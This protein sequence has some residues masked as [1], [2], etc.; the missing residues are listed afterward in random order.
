[1]KRVIILF[2]ILSISLALNSCKAERAVNSEGYSRNTYSI[3]VK[4]DSRNRTMT[5]SEILNYINKN[6]ME[7]LY[8]HLYPNVYKEKETAPEFSSIPKS[9]P[10]GFNEGYIN[11][12]SVKIN[13]SKVTYAVEGSL[14]R[15][16]IPKNMKQKDS[17]KV[18]IAFN[19]LLPDAKTRYGKYEGLTHSS[20]WYPILAVY[21]ENGWD[22]AAFHPIGESSYSE[23]ADY[24]VKITLPQNEIIAA[25]GEKIGERTAS[26]GYKTITYK[27][28]NIRDF[29]WFSSAGF[30]V[31]EKESNGVTYRYYYVDEGN[32]D[33]KEVLEQSI[34][35]FDFYNNKFGAYPYKQFNI[36]N[37]KLSTSEFPE[38][39]TITDA[40]LG[41]SNKLRLAFAH[42]IAHQWWYLT[43]GNN[44]YKEPWLDEALASYSMHLYNE[45]LYGD[46]STK[47]DIIERYPEKSH[48]IPINSPVNKFEAMSDYGDVVY[49]WGSIALNELSNK[50]GKTD[51]YK[52]LNG[53]YNEY[54]FKNAE[55]ADFLGEI[56][57]AADKETAEWFNNILNI[58]KHEAVPKKQREALQAQIM[59][60]EEAKLESGQMLAFQRMRYGEKIL[61]QAI[62]AHS[63]TEIQKYE[64][65]MP[66]LKLQAVDGLELDFINIVPDYE[67]LKRW[68]KDGYGK[69]NY[70]IQDTKDIGACVYSYGSYGSGEDIRIFILP[71]TSVIE[72]NK[73]Y[74]FLIANG[75]KLTENPSIY[76]YSNDKS[77]SAAYELEYK[78]NKFRIIILTHNKEKIKSIA[79]DVHKGLVKK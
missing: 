49:K 74:D 73:Q 40:N 1:M 61:Y 33:Y 20:Y 53:Y 9:Y 17:L 4:Y 28:S 16:E 50:I 72:I 52:V 43:V 75:K 34:S 57:K 77:A 8:F 26:P 10:S 18:Q 70:S 25:T 6:K 71:T 68:A 13:G 59:N 12:E 21:D 54:K 41:D 64:G 24:I 29:A 38:A 32:V 78:G 22:K 37:T 7:E 5:G 63:F 2:L 79:E 3:D 60:E 19:S 47:I 15:A 58:D 67:A 11:I 46:I 39:I 14:L 45:S 65:L 23:A 42:E 62:E 66:I 51:F 56:E 36:V 27:E 35:I 44:Q 55:T 76:I 69:K 31:I 30:K 48:G